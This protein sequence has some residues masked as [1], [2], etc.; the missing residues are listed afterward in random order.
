SSL[1]VKSMR[2]LPGSGSE[3]EDRAGDDAALDLIRA[4]EDRLLAVVE[5]ERNRA[6]HPRG[7]ARG[8][9]RSGGDRRGPADVDD[10]LVDGL[11]ELRAAQLQHRRHRIGL[12]PLRA[13]RNPQGGELE[14][15]QL[16]LELG[17]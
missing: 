7:D 4:A 2:C 6:A 8:L 1:S 10:E 11:R 14:G 3:A 9:A 12:V 5:V 13:A 16:V 17:D 15:E